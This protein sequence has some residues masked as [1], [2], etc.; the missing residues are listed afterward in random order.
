MTDDG[1]VWVDSVGPDG[2]RARVAVHHLHRRA[3]APPILVSHATGFHARAY[4][5]MAAE[6][7]E[8]D[9]WGID[10]RG[11]GSSA[12]P[13]G[14]QVDWRGYGADTLAV[15]RWLADRAEQ[16][17]V[18]FG[19]S[20]GGATLLMAAVADPELFRGLV[21]FEPIA[22]PPQVLP[23]DPEDF[24]LVG[25][26]R[27]RR[28]RFDSIDAAIANYASK[29]PLASIDPRVLRDYVEFG[30][31]P[32]DAPPGVE[33]CCTPDHEGNTFAA[34]G[35]NGVWEL[36]PEVAVP[37]AIVAGGDQD[38]PAEFA[39]MIAERIAGASFVTVRDQTHFGP[40]SHPGAVARLVRDL[41]SAWG[42]RSA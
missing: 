23:A 28:A 6:L 42:S 8:F 30:F 34:S 39:P 18:G 3:D 36:L 31:R 38:G 12:V 22:F 25:G 1:P 14:W 40:F 10:H 19:H 11:H 21:L 33:L 41:A 13:S 37:A 26:A 32:A 16:P 9:V 15:G 29:P 2:V 5:R 20:M 17:L 4:L 7:G 24:P 27:R 35:G